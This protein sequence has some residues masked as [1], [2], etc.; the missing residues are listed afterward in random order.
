MD[1]ML[2]AQEL[3]KRGYTSEKIEKVMGKNLLRVL[4]EVWA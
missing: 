4:E 1:H 3:D 2:I